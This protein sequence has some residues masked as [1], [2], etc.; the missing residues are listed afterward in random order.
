M[1]DA[2]ISLRRALLIAGLAIL[3]LV[4]AACRS[5]PFPNSSNLTWPSVTFRDE[6][7][8]HQRIQRDQS[9]VQ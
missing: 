9:L 2:L 1:S 3:V 4:L 8:S 5:V 7:P 6:C